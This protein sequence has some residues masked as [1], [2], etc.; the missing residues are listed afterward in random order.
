MDNRKARTKKR[1]GWFN[2]GRLVLYTLLPSDKVIKMRTYSRV[3]ICLLILFSSVSA[4]QTPPP[5]A[6]TA[7][8]TGRWRVTFSIAGDPEKHLV[9]EVKPK[10]AGAFTLLDTGPGDKPIPDP[11]PAT[12]SEMDNNRV[13]F[14]SETELQLGDCCREWGTL[15]FKGKFKSRTSITGGLIFVTSIDEEESPY[16]FRSH[17]GTFTATLVN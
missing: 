9:F 14:S 10:G 4:Q 6:N 13:S 7:K 3:F 12:W 1:G 17:I 16:K 11:A 8:L 2:T 15:I 5:P